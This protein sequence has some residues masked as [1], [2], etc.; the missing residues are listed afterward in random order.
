MRTSSV[1][2]ELL[3]FFLESVVRQTDHLDMT[4]AVDRDLKPQTKQTKTSSGEL[5]C[6]VTNLITVK[7]VLSGYSK[8]TPKI[9]FQD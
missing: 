7:P 6:L 4:I 2:E 5:S 3:P 8:R 9:G 1:E